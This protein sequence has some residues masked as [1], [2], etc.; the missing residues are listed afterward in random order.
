V[1]VHVSG[2]GSPNQEAYC[3][4]EETVGF[5][6]SYPGILE[7]KA[8]IIKCV[9][10]GWGPC[11][12]MAQLQIKIPT[13]GGG[14]WENDRKGGPVEEGCPSLHFSVQDI[15]CSHYPLLIGYRTFGIYVFDY[16]GTVFPDAFPTVATGRS[17]LCD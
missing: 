9:G 16:Q 11:T 3:N 10:D 4:T 7:G 5:F 17:A 12:S 6:G 8:A 13:H 14:V 15:G 1:I 2:S